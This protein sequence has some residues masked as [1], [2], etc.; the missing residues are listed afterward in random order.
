MRNKRGLSLALISL[1]CLL[2]VIVWQSPEKV[3]LT[4]SVPSYADSPDK[5]VQHFWRLID[6]RQLELA[7]ACIDQAQPE[8]ALTMAQLE[9]FVSQNPW[10][11][12]NQA[13]IVD[14]KAA[15]LMIVEIVWKTEPQRF[16]R[17]NYCMECQP[18]AAGYKLIQF[19]Q[20]QAEL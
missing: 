6:Q 7:E 1:A 9:E 8:T 4:M 12:V 10:V 11:A 15:G 19:Q 2:G 20:I 18:E 3:W 5:F 13:R 17:Q 14:R 16:S